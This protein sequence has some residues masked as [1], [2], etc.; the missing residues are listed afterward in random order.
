MTKEVP[1]ISNTPDDLH[2]LQAAFMIILK[3]FKPDSNIEWGEWS[4]ITGFEKDKGTWAI[5]GLAWFRDQG[6]DVKH[7]E[8]FD[9]EA[10]ISQGESYLKQRFPGETGDWAIKHTNIQAE[11][12][13]AKRLI[14]LDVFDNREPTIN[15]IKRYIDEGY[16]IRAHVNSR[17]LNNKPGYFGHAVVVFEYDDE[18]LTLHDPGLPALPNRKVLYA[19]FEKAWFDPDDGT[20]EMDAIRLDAQIT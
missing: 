19:D 10:F 15:D 20:A 8:T 11:Q 5:A 1:F 13:R 9:F 14:G 16:L 18:G 12:L 6:F 3:Y 7:I 4:K 2:C 17:Q